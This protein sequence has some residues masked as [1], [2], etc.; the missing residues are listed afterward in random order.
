MWRWIRH[1]RDWL[2]NEIV[3]PRRLA[4]QPQALYFRSEKGGL[5]LENQPV[6]WSAEAVVVEALLR[7]PPA[8]RRRSDFSLRVPGFEPI[9]ADVLRADEAGHRHRLFFRLPVPKATGTAELVWRHHVLGKLE[10]PVVTPEQFL[11][12]LRLTLASAFVSVGGRSVAAQT[13]VTT[14]QQGLSA[15]AVIQSPT[16]LA[17]LLDLGLSATFR[18]A[19]GTKTVVTS[20]PLTASQL[21]GKEALV[22][23]LP[24]RLPRKA[25][26]WTVTWT[27]PGRELATTK[28]RAVTPRAF[29]SSLR[30]SD[31]RF[32]IVTTD[33][34]FRVV[35]QMPAEGVAK[36][37]PCFFVASREPG[38]AGRAEFEIGV[39]VP[40]VDR[41]P[42]VLEQTVLITDGPTPVAPGLIPMAELKHASAFELR[43]KGRVLGVLPLSPVPTATFT[44]EGGYKPPP[45][46]TWSAAAED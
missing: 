46:F 40:G 43:I 9:P 28:L 13:F 12:E 32:G 14:Q 37:G 30:V 6:P 4:A 7:L 18:T 26:E 25:G 21:E 38:M 15:A 41:S 42:T 5:T 2:M 36:A 33:G 20:V 3:T 19:R 45:E 8:A 22:T 31:T 39:Q 17:P 10:I 29:R 35:R 1:W 11:S 34:Q 23:A 27:C 44:A 16:G 24:P